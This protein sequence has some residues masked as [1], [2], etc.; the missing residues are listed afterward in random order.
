MKIDRMLP[1]QWRRLRDMR[2]RLLKADPDSFGSTL[3]REQAYSDEEWTK[4]A[5]KPEV[6]TFFVGE[7]ERDHGISVGAPYK[8]NG[9]NCAGL[10]SMWIDPAT[11]GR[12]LGGKLVD[13]VI[14]WAKDAGYQELCLEV[15]DHNTAAIALYESRGFLPT[16]NTFKMEPPRDHITEHE[17]LLVLRD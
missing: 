16:G 14:E 8:H 9:R 5:K 1:E 2:L 3:E 4:R 15:G 7:N 13:A 12:G 11:R 10:Y 17:R 6:A